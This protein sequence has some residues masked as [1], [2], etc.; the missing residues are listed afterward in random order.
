MKKQLVSFLS[1]FSLVL[2]LSIYYIMLPFT[3][4]NLG[5]DSENLPVINEVEN[6]FEEYFV[7]L[8]V[9]KNESY[10]QLID[11][12]TAILASSSATIEEKQNALIEIARLEDMIEKEENT[13]AAI[14]EAGYPAAYVENYD[15]GIKVIVYKQDATK[16][17]AATVMSLVINEFGLELMPEVSFYS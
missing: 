3:G 2:V 5:K 13:V 14:I 7:S 16:A 1:L 6:S 11:V 15:T 10:E 12:Q 17:D 8:E 9:Q 4:T